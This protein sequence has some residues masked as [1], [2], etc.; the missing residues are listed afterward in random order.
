VKFSD[1]IP[2]ERSVRRGEKGWYT[3]EE[4]AKD[5]GVSCNSAWKKIQELKRAG[6]VDSAKLEGSNRKVYKV[7]K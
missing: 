3:L 2:P 4:V 5:I 6:R 7:I 1:I